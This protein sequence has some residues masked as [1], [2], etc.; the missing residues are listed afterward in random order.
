MESERVK[1]LE[2][3]NIKLVAVNE[4]LKEQIK[5]LQREMVQQAIK[6]DDGDIKRHLKEKQKDDRITRMI[7]EI[8]DYQGRVKRLTDEHEQQMNDK[9]KKIEEMEETIRQK[10]NRINVLVGENKDYQG[11]NKHLKQ[12]MKKKDDRIAELEKQ[13]NEMMPNNKPI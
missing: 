4:L 7:A 2:R 6:K 13:I 5:D 10:D 9:Q 8:K 12:E 11:D 3:E 1:E